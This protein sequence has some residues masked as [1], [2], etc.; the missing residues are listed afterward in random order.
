VAAAGIFDSIV[1]FGMGLGERLFRDG[2]EKFFEGHAGEPDSGVGQ[3]AVGVIVRS[4]F[5]GWSEGGERF[6][7]CAE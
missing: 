7:R 3:R 2:G 1:E 5:G 6:C 4:G